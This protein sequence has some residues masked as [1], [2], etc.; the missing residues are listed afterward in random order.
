[1]KN[2]TPV[3]KKSRTMVEEYEICPHCQK[4]IM[5]KES[6]VDLENFVYHR[7]CYEK[8]PIDRIKPMSADELSKALGWKK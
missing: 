5:E 4:E 8:G 6:F 7:P 1:M 3:I 2:I